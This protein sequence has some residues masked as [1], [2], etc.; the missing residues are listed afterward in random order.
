M[1]TLQ[2]TVTPRE[3]QAVPVTGRS[4]PSVVAQTSEEDLTSLFPLALLNNFG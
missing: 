1:E 2:G 3:A 4:E